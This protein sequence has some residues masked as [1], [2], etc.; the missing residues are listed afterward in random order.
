MELSEFLVRAKINTYA[1][2]GEGGERRLEDGS[3]E[4]VYEEDDWKYRDRYFGFNPFV[5]EEVVWKN[6]KAI[7]AMNYYGRITAKNVPVEE[8]YEFLKKAMKHV[9]E[10]RPFRGP[11]EFREE[12]FKYVDQSE[13][14]IDDFAGIETIYSED[15]KVHELK[16]HGCKIEEK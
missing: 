1:S 16:Y 14:T 12:N 9:K 2:S 11:A 10:D 8:V 7:W 5:G 3:K 4:L 13:G 15:S 6:G